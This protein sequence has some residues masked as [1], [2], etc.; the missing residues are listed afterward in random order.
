MTKAAKTNERAELK[1]FLSRY[2]IAKQN[3]ADLRERLRTLQA[4]FRMTGRTPTDETAKI[5]AMI[6]A[7]IE[8]GDR[9]ILEI[10]EI[11]AILPADSI[12]SRILAL[13]HIDCMGWRDIQRKVYLTRSPCYR[14]YNKGLDRLLEH[15]RVR[16]VIRPAKNRRKKT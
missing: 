2:Y 13:R 7:E 4:D 9:S 6:E 8:A 10:A 16:A 1:K 3:Q 14:Q 11:I 5:E 12:E 15:D